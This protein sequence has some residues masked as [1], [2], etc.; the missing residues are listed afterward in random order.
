MHDIREIDFSKPYGR[1]ST[2][3]P[4]Q[5]VFFIQDGIDYDSA[6]KA[7]D[8]KQVKAVLAKRAADAQKIADEA[9]EAAEALQADAEALI[10]DTGIT[11]TDLKKAQKEG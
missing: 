3:A 4:N 6:G 11:K 1:V 2:T 8:E 7:V 10:K 9:R 5:K